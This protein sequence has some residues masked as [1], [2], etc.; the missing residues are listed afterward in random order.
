MSKNLI[1][2]DWAVTLLGFVII[3]LSLAGLQLTVPE[4][5]W[6]SITELPAKILNGTN[7]LLITV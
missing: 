1:S 5:N 6:S 2:E 3:I 7:L 4:Y